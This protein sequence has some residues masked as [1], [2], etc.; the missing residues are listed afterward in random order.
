MSMGSLNAGDSFRG[1]VEAITPLSPEVLR[2]TVAAEAAFSWAPGQHVALRARGQEVS[3][4]YYSIASADLRSFDAHGFEAHGADKTDATDRVRF[5]LAVNAK[6]A[7]LGRPLKEGLELELSKAGGGPVLSRLRA[8]PQ[9]SLIGIGTGIAPLRAISQA[10]LEDQCAG[11]G[12]GEGEAPKVTLLHGARTVEGCLFLDEMSQVPGLR[13]HPI[14]SRT[15]ER[16]WSG[17]TGHVQDHVVELCSL[18][19]EFCVC[20]SKVMVAELSAQLAEL[21]VP[22]ERIFAEGY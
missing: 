4:S 5:E 16:D 14:L 19:S 22:A 1:Q 6:S 12:E 21:G 9:V 15:G 18:D 2:V 10:L 17:R 8:A 13:Y 7:K 11:K 3:P 20:G